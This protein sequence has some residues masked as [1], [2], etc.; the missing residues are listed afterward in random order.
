MPRTWPPT[1]TAT[2]WPP[3]DDV[4]RWRRA[5]F[6]LAGAAAALPV[7]A[8]APGASSANPSI[9][10]CIDDQGR[11]LTSDRPIAACTNKEQRV[12]NRDGS[13]R[14]IVPPTL[15]AEERAEREAAERRAELQRAAQADAVRR[16]RNLVARFP[17]EAAHNRAREAALDS[18]RAAMKATEKRQAELAAERK[19]LDDEAEF[20]RGKSIPMRLKQQI[21]A[22]DAA[23]EAQK[24]AVVNQQAEV[25]RI[26]RLYDE[27]LARL[28]K[29]WAG[30]PA[31]SLPVT[32]VSTPSAKAAPGRTKTP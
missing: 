25:V 28:R 2:A 6:A 22:N 12:L 7:L 16:D 4:T 26:N 21:D 8:Q 14:R 18:V 10:T 13:L 11:R 29:L 3:G 19:P 23:V 9:Y 15:T 24:A 31:G 1:A 30:A 5:S 17:N 32:T 20:Y 27:E